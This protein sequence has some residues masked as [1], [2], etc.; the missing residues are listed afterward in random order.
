MIDIDYFKKI[1]DQYLS[2][3]GYSVLCRLIMA[4]LLNVNNVQGAVVPHFEK[5]GQGGFER[6]RI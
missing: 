5:G 3:P 4:I 6:C 2:Q 1:D